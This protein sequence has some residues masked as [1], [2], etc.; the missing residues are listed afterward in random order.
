MTGNASIGEKSVLSKELRLSNGVT[1][2]N[3]IAQSAMTE[4]LATGDGARRGS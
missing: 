3:R 4:H 2:S 1:L